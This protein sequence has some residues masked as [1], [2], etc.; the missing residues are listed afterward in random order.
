MQLKEDLY[1]MM[2]WFLKRNWIHILLVSLIFSGCR[3]RI[4]LESV[5]QDFQLIAINGL[6]DNSEGPYFVEVQETRDADRA[7]IPVDVAQVTL[8]DA[9]GNS[10]G[11][12]YQENGRYMC[13]GNVVR[14]VPGGIYHI[15]VRVGNDL[16]T[17]I[18][19]TMPP[20]TLGTNRLEWEEV[21]LPSTTQSGI[22]IETT[23]LEF[24]MFAELP[25]TTE[26]TFLQWQFAETFQI[27][28][29]DFPDPFGAIPLPCYITQN[30]GVQNFYR[31]PVNEFTNSSYELESVIQREVDIS[32]LVKHIFSIYQSSVSERYFNYL[33]QISAL[34]ET[35]GSLF[36][37]PAGR[38]IGNLEHEGNG[39]SVTGFFTAVATDT[40]HMVIYRDEIESNIVDVCLFDVTKFT[41]PVICRDCT[42]VPRSTKIEPY[43]WSQV[44]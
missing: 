22:N 10:E 25:E 14:G 20:V 40:T 44:Q 33:G 9:M 26:P 31:L 43:W 16:Y 35:T 29:T 13:P 2:K 30:A 15:E 5:P 3:E 19:E 32:F 7:P 42:A 24:D 21:E 39:L 27:R 4:F 12:L 23:V 6:I 41:Y 38:V 8:F 1:K 36:D 11:C 18:P 17:S 37:P 34:T 28:E